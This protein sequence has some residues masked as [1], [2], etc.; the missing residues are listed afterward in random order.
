[1][2][3][4]EKIVYIIQNFDVIFITFNILLY[5]NIVNYYACIYILIYFLLIKI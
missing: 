2:H 1:M 4:Y 5:I 3:V